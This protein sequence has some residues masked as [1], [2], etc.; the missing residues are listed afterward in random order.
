MKGERFLHT[1]NKIR[2]LQSKDW[3]DEKRMVEFCPMC[4]KKMREI[5]VT[6]DTWSKS[7]PGRFTLKRQCTDEECNTSVD[8]YF[9]R[10]KPRD[11][12]I[13]RA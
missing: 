4:K 3:L 2:D 7:G 6:D 5:T 12:R 13:I 1:V 10:Q 8:Y 11:G 9:E